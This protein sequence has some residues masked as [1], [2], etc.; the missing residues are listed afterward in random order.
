[1][2]WILAG[3]VGSSF[4][5]SGHGGRSMSPCHPLTLSPPLAPLK[6]L[7]PRLDRRALRL[8]ERRQRQPLAELVHRLVGVEARAVGRQLEQDAVGL[9]E[10]E[11]AKIKAVDR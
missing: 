6:R 5:E 2:T 3:M 9:P 7:Q 1:M 4:R 10:I 11:T 8:E